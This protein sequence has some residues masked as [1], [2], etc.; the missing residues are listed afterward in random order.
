[1]SNDRETYDGEEPPSEVWF[2]N[3]QWLV[4]DYGVESVRP[5]TPYYHFNKERLLE[6][7]NRGGEMYGWPVHLA[8]KTWVDIEA[9]IEVFQKALDLLGYAPQVDKA[10]LEHP[11]AVELTAAPNGP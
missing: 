11:A 4:T 8:E 3:H 10:M 5:A 7:G 2:Q 9:F 6:T 1:M